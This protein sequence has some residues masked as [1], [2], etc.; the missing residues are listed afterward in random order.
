MGPRYAVIDIGTLKVKLLI[1]SLAPDGSLVQHYASNTLTCFGCDMEQNHGQVLTENLMKTIK[2]LKRCRDKLAQYGVRTSRVISTHALRQAR[3]REEIMAWIQAET[4][5][6]VENITAEREAELFFWAVMR[7]FPAGRRYALVDMGGGS[8]QLM[9]GDRLGLERVHLLPTGAARLHELFTKDSQV[10]TSFNTPGDIE[11]VRRYIL[12][13]FMP[14]EPAAGVPII[15]GSSN[16]LDMMQAVGIPL[17]DHPDSPT[18]PYKT[19]ARYLD[20]FIQK[21][22]PLTFAEREAK[23]P[24][25][26]GY[27]WGVDKAFTNILTLADRLG[28]PYIIPS[29]ANVA[30]GFIYAMAA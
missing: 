25:Q 10:D 1:A 4:G 2:E 8:M 21:L 22:L 24:F 12:E 23:Y 20:E 19:Y 7:D 15:Y 18:H 29:N 17:E 14:V 5:F 9:L 27:M 28:S 16:V 6:A 11:K 30:Q 3:N 13:Q 26:W